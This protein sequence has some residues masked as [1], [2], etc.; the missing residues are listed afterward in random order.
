MLFSTLDPIQIFRHHGFQFTAKES[1][2][3]L[4]YGPLFRIVRLLE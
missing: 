2:Q 3:L 4:Y 1:A